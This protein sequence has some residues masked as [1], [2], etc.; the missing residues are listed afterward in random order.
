MS[1]P[2]QPQ[3]KPNNQHPTNKNQPKPGQ[4]AGHTLSAEAG[5]GGECGKRR[6]TFTA[7]QWRSEFH[8]RPRPSST[9]PQPNQ[10]RQ[11]PNKGQTQQAE[12]R[13]SENNCPGRAALRQA[14][15]GL[16]T[17]SPAEAIQLSRKKTEKAAQRNRGEKVGGGKYEFGMANMAT[18]IKK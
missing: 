14:H 1:K 7:A 17:V 8:A 12:R 9:N 11:N 6:L 4:G 18:I 15:H 3:Q 10:T 13:R 2:K 5:E 16:D